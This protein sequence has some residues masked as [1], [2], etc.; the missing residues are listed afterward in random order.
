MHYVHLY[1]K[2]VT[3]EEYPTNLLVGIFC[4]SNNKGYILGRRKTSPTYVGTSLGK[5]VYLDHMQDGVDGVEVDIL[6]SGIRR[7][8]IPLH[9]PTHIF[10]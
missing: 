2:S 9:V 8:S 4:T 5:Y 1:T 7:T 3:V 6:C 10:Q